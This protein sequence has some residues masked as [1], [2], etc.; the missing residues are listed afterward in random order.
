M[1]FSLLE[2]RGHLLDFTNLV[3]SAKQVE[4]IW[5]DDFLSKQV[6]NDFNSKSTAIHVVAQE[7]K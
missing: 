6:G 2:E 7:K 3:I 1:D 5:G 4:F